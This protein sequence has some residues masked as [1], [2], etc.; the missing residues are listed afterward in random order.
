MSDGH[1]NEQGREIQSLRSRSPEPDRGPRSLPRGN[2]VADDW[3]AAYDAVNFLARK[4]VIAVLT[5]LA[6]GPRRHNELARAIGVDH[7]SLDRVLAQLQS[8]NLVER[9]VDVAA[10]PLQ[11]YYRLPPRAAEVRQPLAELTNWWQRS[12]GH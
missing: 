4:W 9:E 10:P 5:E 3:Q 6:N 11:V 8:A 1:R 12:C 2:A 7:R